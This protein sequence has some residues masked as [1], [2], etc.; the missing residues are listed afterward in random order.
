MVELISTHR[1]CGGASGG[2]IRIV[3]VAT[4][5]EVGD[6]LDDGVGDAVGDTFSAGAAEV[7]GD[8]ETDGDT[9]GCDLPAPITAANAHTAAKSFAM[10][11]RF[12]V[13][14]APYAD[15]AVNC[16]EMATKQRP[17]FAARTSSCL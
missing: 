6:T 9:V 1:I 4:G 7:E 3:G 8:G 10:K 11:R 12:V 2:S 5:D 14:M 16:S 17:F 13:A 15:Y